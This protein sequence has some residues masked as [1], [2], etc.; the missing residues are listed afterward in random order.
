MGPTR[1]YEYLLLDTRPERVG[2]A[3]VVANLK[4]NIDYFEAGHMIKII[5][6]NSLAM[7]NLM[8]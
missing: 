7:E 5:L 4:D 2:S 1:E 3:V 6:K 8:L